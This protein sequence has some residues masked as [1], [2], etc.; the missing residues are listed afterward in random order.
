LR[1]KL[2]PVAGCSAGTRAQPRTGDGILNLLEKPGHRCLLQ[3][4]GGQATVTVGH[5]WMDDEA[6]TRLVFI[7]L[8]GSVD[9]QW[10]AEGL[11]PR[12]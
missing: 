10:I 6:E 7:G 4:S 8:S 3:V 9:A 1:G 12:H 5:P 2:L 11:E